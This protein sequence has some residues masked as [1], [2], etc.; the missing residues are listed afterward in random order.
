M[1]EDKIVVLMPDADE[2]GEKWLDKVSK[3]LAGRVESLSIITVPDKFI[4]KYPQY[5]GHDFADM[6]A[7]GGAERSTEWLTD[8]YMK[9]DKIPRGIDRADLNVMTDVCSA[10]AYNASNRTDADGMNLEH[11]FGSEMRVMVRPADLMMII[12]PT[13][14]GKTRVLANM[15]FQY[16]NL[17]FMVFDLELSRDQIGMRGIA[18]HNDMSYEAADSRC[19]NGLKMEMPTIENVFVPRVG[20]LTTKKIKEEVDR[21]EAMQE[22][23][24]H[25]V[26]IDYISK[27]NAMGKMQESIIQN[28]IEFKRY[29]VEENRIGIITTQSKRIQDKVMKYNMP[30]KEDAIFTSTLEQNCQQAMCFCFVNGDHNTMLVRCDKYTNGAEPKSWIEMDVADMRM[31]Y[32][33]VHHSSGREWE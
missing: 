16:T 5:K 13:G 1:L 11:M 14:V 2:E 24:I 9:A 10:A 31:K 29:L 33:G 6:L 4:L 7:E 25:V 27:M 26:A 20:N 21:V 18:Y 17:N 32:R 23:K 28:C 12:A 15:M 30:R 8:Q 19:Q 3:G 22:R